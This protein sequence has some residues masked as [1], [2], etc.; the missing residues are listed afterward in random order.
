[1]TSSVCD[2]LEVAFFREGR[3]WQRKAIR[4]ST[5][6]RLQMKQQKQSPSRLIGTLKVSANK[7]CW[8]SFNTIRVGVYPTR[9]GDVVKWLLRLLLCF[10]FLIPNPLTQFGPYSN[11]S[12]VKFDLGYMNMKHLCPL[13]DVPRLSFSSRTAAPSVFGQ[14]SP[15]IGLHVVLG[16]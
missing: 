2:C 13:P 10:F 4:R 9:D 12:Q 16:R 11:S 15:L 7:K 3:R 14:N 8:F 5:N 6:A 1:M